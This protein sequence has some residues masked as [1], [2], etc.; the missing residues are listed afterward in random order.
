MQ[1]PVLVVVALTAGVHAANWAS[2]TGAGGRGGLCLRG[3]QFYRY[4]KTYSQPSENACK[5]KCEAYPACRSVSFEPAGP[6]CSLNTNG[7]TLPGMWAAYST[8]GTAQHPPDSVTYGSYGDSCWYIVPTVAPTVAPTAA[9]SRPPSGTP[10]TSPS[11]GPTAAPLLPSASPTAAPSAGPSAQPSR[12]PTAPPSVSPTAAPSRPPTSRPTSSPTRGPSSEPTRRPS[13][14]PTS[15]PSAAPSASPSATPS[16]RPSAAP[17]SRPSATPSLPP[18]AGP[19]AAPS[20]A[21]TAAP[22]AAPSAAPTAAPSAGPSAGP[23]ATPSA[24]PSAA[25]STAPSAGP[26]AAPSRAPSRPPSRAPS[27]APSAA[28]SRSPSRPPS[29]APTAVPSAAPSSAPS[30]T[31]SAAPSVAPSA[32]PSALPSGSPSGGPTARP[33]EPPTAGPTLPPSEAPSAGPTLPP[34][35][36]PTV[37]P[38]LQPSQP[39]TVAPTTTAPTVSPSVRP[40]AGP[41]NPPSPA[42]S[43]QPALPPTARPSARP[44]APPWRRPTGQPEAPP[45]TARPTEPAATATA[46]HVEEMGLPG[47]PQPPPAAVVTAAGMATL[48]GLVTGSAAA[49]TQVPRIQMLLR[50]C[51]PD[52]GNGDTLDFSLHPMAIAFGSDVY[53]GAMLMNPVVLAATVGA[54][55]LT[56]VVSARCA[57]ADLQDVE[58]RLRWPT[59]VAGILLPFLWQGVVYSAFQR[60][61]TPVYAG[62]VVCAALVSAACALLLVLFVGW[63]T[64]LG[65]GRAADGKRFLAF[66]ATAEIDVDPARKGSW[67][68][69]KEFFFGT[70]AWIPVPPKLLFVQCF[71][72]LFEMCVEQHKSFLAVELAVLYTLALLASIPLTYPAECAAINA[73]TC[74]VL[75]AYLAV[76]T[77]QKPYA[78]AYD[79]VFNSVLT[80]LEMLAVLFLAAAMVLEDSAHWTFDACAMCLTVALYVTIVKLFADVV[81]LAVDCAVGTRSRRRGAAAEPLAD[82]DDNGGMS[83]EVSG[84]EHP[85]RMDSFAVTVDGSLAPITSLE[86]LTDSFCADPPA[87]SRRRPRLSSVAARHHSASLCSASPPRL[88]GSPGT[89]R[90]QV[91][92]LED[93]PLSQRGTWQSLQLPALPKLHAGQPASF[94][95][96]AADAPSAR[97]ATGPRPKSRLSSRSFSASGPAA[98]MQQLPSTRGLL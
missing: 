37:G 75:A 56:A 81:L 54:H 77:L 48:S 64:K 96:G 80:C 11:G 79:N 15:H 27:A 83:R 40:S 90:R 76:I 57:G 26:S 51:D 12:A 33:S 18:S 66:Y 45:A 71:G 31:P 47:L 63:T 6:A 24:A 9:P 73:L 95:G 7:E 78:A 43:Q 59:G 4:Y 87:R 16:R 69:I 25:P 3:S 28:P 36:P 97:P 19:S 14:G 49:G 23:S 60:L 58:G 30:A 68:T 41:S 5:T 1:R 55:W 50:Q 98:T 21:P 62:S 82:A 84:S 74:C 42:P 2:I 89:P 72:V 13:L 35:E 88:R 17:S 53:L 29:R 94:G 38:T 34:S 65:E 22:S 10:T 8:S 86:D 85:I 67:N 44:S 46:T 52:A 61:F 20:A 70:V 32:P 39:P 92:R 93:A 91:R